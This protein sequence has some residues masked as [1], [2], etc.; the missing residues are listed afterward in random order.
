MLHS[1]LSALKNIA[2]VKKKKENRCRD[3]VDDF[4]K[5]VNKTKGKKEEAIGHCYKK[6]LVLKRDK[7]DLQCPVLH[8]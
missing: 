5:N 1:K 3:F 6:N 7:I 8:N 2:K 4:A